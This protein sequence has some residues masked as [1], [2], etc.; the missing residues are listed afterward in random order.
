MTPVLETERL[1]LRGHRPEDFEA[2]A[3]F[4]GSERARFIGKLD[5]RQ[6]WFEFGAVVGSWTL[7]GHGGW[8][9]DL[10]ET[11][12]FIG[13]VGVMQPESFPELELGWLMFDGHEGKGYACEAA[14]A[15]RDWAFGA[16]GA[17][18]LVSYIDPENARSV[19]LAERLGAVRDMDAAGPDAGD[20]VY[21]HPAPEVRQ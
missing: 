4:L 19:A 21:R 16:H 2:Y 12:D 13:Q 3:G 20:L 1:V 11:G 7:Y 10:R 9:V 17:P 5:R 15:A 14:A 6:A 18:T 8:A